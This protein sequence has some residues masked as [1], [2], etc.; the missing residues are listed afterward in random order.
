MDIELKQ[1][2]KTNEILSAFI[3]Q[4]KG[5]LPTFLTYFDRINPVFKPF[6][7]FK[8]KIMKPNIIRYFIVYND[9]NVGE[10]ELEFKENLI[11]ISD[12]FILKKY[13]N[14]GIGQCAL[15]K[16]HRTYNNYKNWHLFTIKQD[17]RNC[18][19]YEKLGYKPTGIE[20]IINK[21]MTIIEYEKENGRGDAHVAL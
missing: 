3:M 8:A 6:T 2:K 13:Q 19:L 15:N 5:F 14:I 1:I 21:R 7:A 9:I 11:H 20:H 17:K 12:F 10:I 4:K 18:H 16:L